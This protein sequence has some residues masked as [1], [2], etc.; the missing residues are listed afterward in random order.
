MLNSFD[1]ACLFDSEFFDG[2]FRR[3]K[4]RS[5]HGI[6]PLVGDG[7]T[8]STF[9]TWDARNGLYTFDGGDCLKFR[10]V[11]DVREVLGTIGSIQDETYIFFFAPLISTS[12][13]DRWFDK[14]SGTIR[15]FMQIDDLY[16]FEMQ[17]YDGSNLEHV[18]SAT[19]AALAFQGRGVMAAWVRSQ[20]SQKLYIDAVNIL[21]DTDIQRDGS[22]IGDAFIGCQEG[23]SSF[24]PNGT[25]L[26]S[27]LF[28]REALTENK[29]R[30]IKTYF[31][32]LL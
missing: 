8:S 19:N 32:E 23:T 26:K 1:I 4:D 22:S 9:P 6:H 12:N 13:H 29:L 16:R 15:I 28:A 17:V 5:R 25:G 2:S 3:T 30:T 31:E 18:R 7:T 27:F 11:D 10:N 21:S 20:G 24:L 14:R